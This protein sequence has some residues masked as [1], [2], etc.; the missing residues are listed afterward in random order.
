M[1]HT[2]I[3][4][5]EDIETETSP[6]VKAFKSFY[7]T[8]LQCNEFF[9]EAISIQEFCQFEDVLVILD[10]DNTTT[11]EIVSSCFEFASR[12]TSLDMVI[13]Y[14]FNTGGEAILFVPG[15]N[16]ID[17]AE[18]IALLEKKYKCNL[19]R[20]LGADNIL[21][22][23]DNLNQEVKITALERYLLNKSHG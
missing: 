19:I 7:H 12:A 15:T 13:G 2:I 21:S 11:K 16:D 22:L 4:T 3:Y 17:R 10:D 9:E 5:T 8:V 23:F 14:S 6:D 18:R 1:N 20:H